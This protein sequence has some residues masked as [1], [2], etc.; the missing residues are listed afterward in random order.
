MPLFSLTLEFVFVIQFDLF[1]FNHKTG[2]CP[3]P[4]KSLIQDLPFPSQDAVLYEEYWTQSGLCIKSSTNEMVSGSIMCV[5][6]T[7]FREGVGA[8]APYI[9]L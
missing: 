1:C 2:C 4:S 9:L 7:N 3:P 8:A 6:L 5:E